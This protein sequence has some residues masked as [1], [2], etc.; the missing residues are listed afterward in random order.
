MLLGFVL[1]N[2]A[3]ATVAAVLHHGIEQGLWP[4]YRC[5]DNHVASRRV[6]E[7]IGLDVWFETMAVKVDG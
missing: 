5:V 4:Q 3:V 7:S 6:A 1:A 2:V